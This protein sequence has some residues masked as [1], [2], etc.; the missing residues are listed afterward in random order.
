[1]I[2]TFG[3]AGTQSE[4]VTLELRRKSGEI[5]KTLLLR[6]GVNLWVALRRFGIPVGA[7]CSGVGVCGKCA[8]RNLGGQGIELTPRTELEEQT[9]SRQGLASDLRLAC[10]CRVNADTA[11]QADYW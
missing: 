1:M 10:L 8:V 9:L 5:L 4:K 7:S 11:I 6:K 3:Q 2:P